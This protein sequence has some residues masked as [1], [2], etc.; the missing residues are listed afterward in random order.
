M[1]RSGFDVEGEF[2]GIS[3]RLLVAPTGGRLHRH[4][5]REG[6]HLEPGTVIGEL[7]TPTGR[8]QVRSRISGTFLAWVAAEGMRV[9]TG[10]ALAVVTPDP[11][12][13]GGRS[14]VGRS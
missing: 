9:T 8:V 5:V 11:D 6:R 10:G 13:A 1:I 14:S 3:Q 2:P 4:R 7:R 12:D